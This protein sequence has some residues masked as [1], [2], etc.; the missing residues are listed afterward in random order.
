MFFLKDFILKILYLIFHEAFLPVNIGLLLTVKITLNVNDY[1]LLVHA[2]QEM[3][4]WTQLL[5]SDYGLNL[6]EVVFI[7]HINYL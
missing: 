5:V 3:R 4:S 6:I 7:C 2:V 1:M